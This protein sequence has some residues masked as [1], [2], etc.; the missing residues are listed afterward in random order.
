MKSLRVSPTTAIL[1][2]LIGAAGGYWIGCGTTSSVSSWHEEREAEQHYQYINPLLSCDGAE[3]S[4]T[5]S[6]TLRTLRT[7]LQGIVGAAYKEGAVTR[8][9]IYIRELNGGVWLGINEREEF[10]PG[11]LLK[12]PAV[13]SLYRY[14]EERDPSILTREFEFGGGDVGAAQQ[15]APG[16]SLTPGTIYSMA[17]LVER[18]LRYSDNN[19]ATLIAQSIDTAY[20]LGAYR[21]LGFIAPTLGQDYLIRV[22]DYA[23]FF[24]LLYNAT[25]IDRDESEQVL[26]L[27]AQ[28]TFKKGI[29]AGV[30]TGTVV[31]HK[32][33]ER[34]TGGGLQQLHDCGIVYA[35]NPYIICVLSQGK[36]F[37]ALE[38][39]IARVSAAAYEGLR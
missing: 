16:E 21:D 4:N 3:L 11:S 28:S 32:F 39:F 10:T 19:A 6:E 7:K 5:S 1:L 37:A 17:N 30:P 26:G 34:E 24:R 33:G 9:A 35:K 2:V 20:L 8:S 14:A 23:A 22:K 38:S 31:A 13:M 29:V 25:Y 36:D 27:L 15:Y 12:V 18:A